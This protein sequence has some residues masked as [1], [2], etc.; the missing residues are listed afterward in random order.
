MNQNLNMIIIIIFIIFS[1]LTKNFNFKLF[2]L[3]IFILFIINSFNN[4]N[5][6][7]HCDKD[8]NRFKIELFLTT[9]SENTQRVIYYMKNIY[10]EKIVINNNNFKYNNFILDKQNTNICKT[11]EANNKFFC[12][13]YKINY[14]NLLS[15]N[16]EIPNHYTKSLI[17]YLRSLNLNEKKKSFLYAPGDKH[18]IF[19]QKGVIS[20]SRSIHDNY[21]VLLKLNLIRHW[22]PINTVI[23]YD[24]DFSSKNDKLI[25]RGGCTGF[26]HKQNYRLE[27]VKN[28]CKHSEIDIGFIYREEIDE[29]IQSLPNYYFKPTINLK[30]LLKYKY[31]ISIEGND[32]SSGLKWQLFSNSVVFMS[33]P[34]IIS[35][36]M[37]DQLIP[38]Y[39][40]IL[41][42]DDFSDLEE[43]YLWAKNNP[44]KC[45][46]INNN[47]K[48]FIKKFLNINNEKNISLEIIRR[49]FDNVSF[50]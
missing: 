13:I 15:K 4:N 29:N 27:L 20:K 33:K 10:Y 23:K 16:I 41:I 28:F 18:K 1:L 40:Y 36:C 2:I 32:V 38:N 17:D 5:K 24:K 49:Y 8:I 44:S 50:E 34:K 37:E 9:N 43:K 47:S 3:I 30:D 39:H 46:E 21:T 45:L 25:W 31:H 19:N 22:S 48:V 42:K 14:N 26:E 6:S 7:N 35:W 12:K 11:S